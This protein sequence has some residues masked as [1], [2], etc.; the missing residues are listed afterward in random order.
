M[1]NV[2]MEVRGDPARN[3][4]YA[5]MMEHVYP[6]RKSKKLVSV[7]THVAYKIMYLETSKP[8]VMF[9]N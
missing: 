3:I 9:V 2:G 7:A 5:L 1:E 8:S 4:F 6:V